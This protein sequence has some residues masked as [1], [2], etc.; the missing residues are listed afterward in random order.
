MVTNLLIILV[1]FAVVALCAW[2]ML[3]AW[4]I[5]RVAARVPLGVLTGLLTLV[6]L[7]VGVI[8]ARGAYQVYAP[9]RFP[10]TTFQANATPEQVSQGERWA[11]FTCAA[12][13]ST[14]GDVPLAGGENLA[15]D[16]SLPIGDIYPPNLTPAGPVKEW[17]DAQILSALREGVN[18]TGRALVGMP[19]QNLRHLSDEDA[20]AIIGYLR[21]QPAT[22]RE[23]PP[24]HAS[25]LTLALVGTGVFALNPQPV[26]GPVTA[27]PR[28]PDAAY[29]EY[30]V[31][32]SDCRECHGADLKGGKSPGPIG[33]NLQMVKAWN[34][35]QFMQAMR[36]GI[37]PGG[38]QIQ[39]PMPWQQ[40]G[41]MDDVELAAVWE[42]LHALE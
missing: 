8:L 16:F 10:P 25:P 28:A 5:R 37:D 39:P 1:V 15:R 9:R 13:H 27:P 24:I 36:T 4:R 18:P 30:I 38:H 40:V 6:F 41:R 20:A 22:A 7:A 29:G 17:T 26:T 31:S 12:C 32:F 33:P 21:S 11:R 34:Q 23:T 42:Y 2:L 35:G 14:T 19:Y 3:R